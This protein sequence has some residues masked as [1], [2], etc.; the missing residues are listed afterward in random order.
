MSFVG[1]TEIRVNDI[2]KSFRR[3]VTMRRSNP[4]QNHMRISSLFIFSRKS[5]FR[6]TLFKI[7]IDPNVHFPPSDGKLVPFDDMEDT[8]KREMLNLGFKRKE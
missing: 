2:K 3:I 4:F 7:L 6:Q 5:E 1:D 8:Q